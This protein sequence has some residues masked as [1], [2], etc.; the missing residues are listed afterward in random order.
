MNVLK[1]YSE[2]YQDNGMLWKHK[3]YFLLTLF[4]IFC[5]NVGAADPITDP[6]N[7]IQSS[8]YIKVVFGL[9]FV[10]ALFL[11]S[12][13]LFK[14]FGNGPMLG[15]GQLRV[16]DGLHLGNRER[17]MLV[18]L[19]DKQILLAI[20]PGCIKKIDTLDSSSS[21]ESVSESRA[22]HSLNSNNQSQAEEINA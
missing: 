7:A 13:Y 17:L 19:K 22:I 12:S 20:T 9:A 15:R 10:I 3:K 11:I 5:N 1:N 18:E 14:R 21:E 4:F 8:D 2:A 6:A 16:V